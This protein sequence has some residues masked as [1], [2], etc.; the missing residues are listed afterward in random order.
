MMYYIVALIA[1]HSDI[2]EVASKRDDVRE[3]LD[4]VTEGSLAE[5]LF[6]VFLTFSSSVSAQQV[7]ILCLGKRLHVSAADIQVP[8]SERIPNLFITN[9]RSHG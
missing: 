8:C 9:E 7:P 5:H 2:D 3:A 4:R 1:E 6:D